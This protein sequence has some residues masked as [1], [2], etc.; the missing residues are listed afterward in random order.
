MRRIL[1]A[2]ALLFFPFLLA[3]E[4]AIPI[5]ANL[6]AEG[7]PPIPASL[8]ET[9]ARYNEVRSATLL[10]WHPTERAMLISTRFGD[11]PQVHFVR[12]PG[13]ARTQLTFFPDR[14][15]GARYRPPSGE[16]FV[17]A[18]DVGGAEF[19]QL[20]LFNTKSGDI[21][22]LTDGRSR[23]TAAH[24]SHDG[25]LL[26]YSST[27]RNGKDTDIYVVDPSTPAS[28][29]RLL[30]VEGGGWAAVD[31]SPDNAKLLVGE[32]RSIN[33]NSL[34]LVDV[35]TGAKELL[36]PR[37]DP[38]AYQN[39]RFS[40]DGRGLYLTTDRDS[41]FHRLA[42]L[43]LAPRQFTFL[44]PDLKQD[45][46]ALALSRDGRRLA[47]VVNEDGAAALHLMDTQTLKDLTLP[48]LPYGVIG[49]VQWHS[50]GRD[51]GFT[52]TSA[53]GTD[54]F[55]ID[56]EKETLDRW[57]MSETGGLNAENFVEPELIRWKSF[58]GRM[59]SGLLYLP[60]KKFS[61]P[62]QVIINIHGGPEGQS[63]PVFLGRN[64]YYLNELGVGIIYP[65][66]R[67][68]T[69]YSKTFSTLDNGRKREDSVRD[70][71]ALLDWI[72]ARPDLDSRRVLV[73]GGSYGGYMTL[74]SMVHFNDRLC[75]GLEIV[76]VSNFVTLLQR[77][78]AYRR[79]L[80]RVEYGD[81]RDPSMRDFLI[82][83][84]PLT[85]AARITKPMMIASGKN[86]PRV[87]VTESQQMTAAIRKNGG[88]VW[89]LEAEDEGHGY[90][91]KKNQDFYFAASVLFVREYLLRSP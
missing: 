43:D 3:G 18:K 80:R 16:S 69:G 67:G 51:L 60:G 88:T 21:S 10:D 54:V 61:A 75:C 76:G 36:T 13:A 29:R 84:S 26:A 40:K 15:S 81:E 17:L 5:P 57:T 34:F 89:Y 49:A 78:E 1:L 37:G 23:N 32:F 7:I 59:I 70:I 58:D 71:G 30:E 53:K 82:S 31:W 11:T 35:G 83:I 28:T 24:W 4:R 47:Y 46:E 14:V 72:A 86:D 52:L 85:N 50:N 27:R 12:M 44:R 55:S 63:R 68:S 6:K 22:L 74:A 48:R 77:T 41:E 45:V 42:Y 90:A 33:E 9:L 20:Y 65:N 19:F 64:N 66:V 73:T 8:M 79:D 91:K 2:F 38:A 87:P 25:R 39:A 56:V 62:H